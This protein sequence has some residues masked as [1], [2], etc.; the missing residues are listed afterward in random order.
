[1]GSVQ[2][3][4]VVAFGVA[5]NGVLTPVLEVAAAN[6][7]DAIDRARSLGK[8]YAGAIAFS[9][10]MDLGRSHYGTAKIHAVEGH[11]PKDVQALGCERSR[12]QA[13]HRIDGRAISAKP[14]RV[15]R[16]CVSNVVRPARWQR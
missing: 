9:R 6:P 11:V 4:V 14:P 3:H 1:M 7:Q 8:A 13:L 15:K 16:T 2:Y 12:S 10:T 5:I